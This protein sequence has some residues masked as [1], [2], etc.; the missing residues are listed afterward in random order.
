MHTNSINNRLTPRLISVVVAST[1]AVALSGCGG[2]GHAAPDSADTGTISVP[3]ADT[4]DIADQ[5][6]PVTQP[7]FPAN[8]TPTTTQ[9]PVTT[10]N[11]AITEPIPVPVPTS[12]GTDTGLD[13]DAVLRGVSLVDE[14]IVRDAPG[15][16]EVA[17]L[18]DTTAFGT[19]TVVSVLDRTPDWVQVLVPIRPNDLSGWV[20]TEDVRLESVDAEIHID[21]ASRTLRLVEDGEPAGQWSVAVGRPD[22]PTPVGRFFITDKLATG[23]ADSVWGAHAFG[24]SAYSEVLTD[25]IGGIGQI[26][27]HGTN[28]PNSIG[29]AASSGCIRLPNEV[30]DDL[31]DRVPL[32]T[33]VHIT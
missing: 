32:G 20:R 10:P 2:G 11:P 19:P 1:A 9:A 30:I 21:L 25:F 5:P 8:S 31:I 33:P 24:V 14:L 29:N 18:G 27:V 17:V 13:D 23:D 6:S 12:A 3:T 4:A 15:G 26:G 22:R 7:P 16:N 28:D